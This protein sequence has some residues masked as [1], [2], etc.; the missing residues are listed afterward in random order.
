ML[1]ASLR[2]VSMSTHPN[3]ALIQGA[4]DA[5]ANRD[6]SVLLDLIADDVRWHLPGRHPHAGDFEG[7]DA[8]LAHWRDYGEATGASHFPPV[9]AVLADDRFAIAIEHVE[10][11]RNGKSYNRHDLVVYRIK[12]GK[13]VEGWVYPEN[14]YEIDDLLS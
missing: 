14:P 6:P 5:L 1:S 2:W 11:E 4:Y 12:D 10:L 3:A 13:I 7:K 8:L 9:L